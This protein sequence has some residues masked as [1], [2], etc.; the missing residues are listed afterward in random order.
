[1]NYF[2]DERKIIDWFQTTVDIK[3]II[4]PYFTKNAIKVFRCI[5]KPYLWDNWTEN[6]SKSALPP[7]FYSEKYKLMMEVMRVDDHGHVTENGKFIN[8]TNQRETVLQKEIRDKIAVENPRI[9]VSKLD[10]FINAISGLPSNDDHNYRYCYENF[11]RT[12]EKHIKKIPLY[13]KNHPDKKLIFFIFDES[14][15][16]LQTTNQEIVKQGPIAKAPYCGYPVFHYNDKKLVEVFLNKDIDYVIW[17]TP[18]KV[19]HGS[20]QPYPHVCIFDIK[21]L[22]PQ[23]MKSYPEELII[24][25]EA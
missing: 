20:N 9:D 21:K 13:R 22:K 2:D 8:P 3:D 15:A 14:T 4:C 25:T 1:M 18:Y 6:C 12:I 23:D 16:Y 17:H 10:I 24:S 7:D 5:Y 11:N 19:L